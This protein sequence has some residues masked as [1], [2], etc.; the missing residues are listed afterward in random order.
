MPVKVRCGECEHVFAAPDAARG[1]A[2][3]CPKCEKRV[4]VPSGAA[5]PG[6]APAKK[7]AEVTAPEDDHDVLA[8]I[9]LSRVEDTSVK[10]CPKC[11]TQ[12]EEDALAC[13][14]CGTDLISG[15]MSASARRKK[16]LR[17]GVD[18]R[19]FFKVVRKDSLAFLKENK[20][21]ALRTSIYTIVCT[22]LMCLCFL[23]AA[24]C[25]AM[26]P[27]VFWGSLGLLFFL[28]PPGWMLSLNCEII[29]AT[30]EK[31]EHMPRVNLDSFGSIALGIKTIVWM[32]VVGCQ[33]L[34][35]PIGVFLLSKGLL[36]VGGILVGISA[37]VLL[38][39]LPMVMGHMAMP[40]TQRGWLLHHQLQCLGKT[41]GAC[42]YFCVMKIGRAHV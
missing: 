35:L 26:P 27:R 41:F 24:W 15:G 28:L 39:I 11:G 20:N 33:T 18:P 5:K 25:W 3:K 12:V 6:K 37:L 10:V 38:L 34:L 8:K 40:Q 1:K 13:E 42:A 16:A 23:V 9:D 17:G 14:A 2:V 32:C 7:K 22:I 36:I 4:P 29:N 30:V 21:L 31:K 19:M